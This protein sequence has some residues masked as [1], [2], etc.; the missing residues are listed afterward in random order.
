MAESIESLTKLRTIERLLI[1]IAGGLA[2]AA[3]AAML[4]QGPRDGALIL[5]AI[6][7]SLIH[8]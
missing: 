2:L 8:I 3:T 5:A 7:L 6:V 4:V 1:L